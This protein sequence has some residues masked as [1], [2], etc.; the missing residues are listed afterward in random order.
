MS[1]LLASLQAEFRDWA[2]EQQ[3][4][5]VLITSFVRPPRFAGDES[6][7]QL[8]LAADFASVSKGELDGVAESARA[9]G[10]VAVWEVDHLHV[11][12]FRAGFLSQCGLL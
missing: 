7:H 3:T 6:Q 1:R 9:L 11:Q 2:F 12:R 8:G 4:D 10:Y 5:G